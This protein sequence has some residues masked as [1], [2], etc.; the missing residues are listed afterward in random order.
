MK[1]KLN[2]LNTEPWMQYRGLCISEILWEHDPI[3]CR[4]WGVPE[5]EYE[6]DGIRLGLWLGPREKARDIEAIIYGML[7][8]CWGLR[9]DRKRIKAAVRDILELDRMTC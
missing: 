1:G 3:G 9:P 2:I 6:G 4:G 7:L 8:G 5:D